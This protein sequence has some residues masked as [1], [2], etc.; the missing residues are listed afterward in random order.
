MSMAALDRPRT[1]F[2]AVDLMEVEFP[3]PR[4]AIPGLIAEGFTFFAGAPKM[5]KS[6]MALNIAVAV[7][8][9]GHALGKISVDQ[10]DVLY[11]ALEDSPRRLQERLKISLKGGPVP[12][13]LH[14]DTEWLPLRDGGDEDLDAW[15]YQ[16][17]DCRLVVVDVFAK[18]RTPAGEKADRY[19]ADYMSAEPLKKLAD[20]HQTAI[21]AVHHTRKATAE[22]FLES[23]SGTNGLAGV[24]DTTLVLKRSR[25]AVDAELYVTGRDVEEQKL[26]LSFSPD[27]G[28]WTLQGDARQ[29]AVSKTR[30]NIIE[31]IETATIPLTPKEISELCPDVSHD[32]VRQ[33][34]RKMA[35]DAQL[36]AVG[37]GRYV[38]P[39][40]RSPVHSRAVL[41]VSEVNEVNGLATASSEEVNRVN[42]LPRTSDWGSVDQGG[43]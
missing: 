22:D 31:A 43:R 21:I 33:L 34:V 27:V 24:A 41:S 15:L 23:V 3:P 37:G 7:A 42:D 35:D 17:P 30:R 36:D 6:W 14:F 39:S 28:V 2:N 25:T 32:T 4:W 1:R 40:L 26:A 12:D 16:H 11:L 8:S 5:G 10:G 20:R 29:W 19:M 38:T 13:R 18:I 9:G